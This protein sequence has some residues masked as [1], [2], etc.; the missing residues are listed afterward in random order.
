MHN[1]AI[2]I[3]LDNSTD[4]NIVDNLVYNNSVCGIFIKSFCSRNRVFGNKIGWNGVNARCD[5]ANN[6]WDDGVS[7]GNSWSD[8][9]FDQ[10]IVPGEGQCIDHYPSLWVPSCTHEVSELLML[11]G[12]LIL[13]PVCILVLGSVLHLA[14]AMIQR[15]RYRLVFWFRKRKGDQDDIIV[16]TRYR[17]I[18]W[19]HK[20]RALKHVDVEETHEPDSSDQ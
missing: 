17:L 13:F 14:S 2:G 20:R 19:L 10:Y 3:H 15:T 11:R 12:V 18:S 8:Y 7:R 16:P 6:S 4:C 9:Y 1:N 5:G